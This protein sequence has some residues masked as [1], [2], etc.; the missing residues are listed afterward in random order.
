MPGRVM[1][2]SLYSAL[3]YTKFNA[4]QRN[5]Y[6]MG[7]HTGNCIAGFVQLTYTT[8]VW[9]RADANTMTLH[10]NKRL[11]C[12]SHIFKGTSD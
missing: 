6:M 7:T 11:V 10:A 5:I 1:E 9:I 12:F 2:T 4:C 8:L 3:S